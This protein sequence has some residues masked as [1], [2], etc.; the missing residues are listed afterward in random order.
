MVPHCLQVV[1]MV[2]NAVF[3][4]S[5]FPLVSLC[6]SVFGGVWRSGMCGVYVCEG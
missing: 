2:L 5:K 1:K 6:D 4:L 3:S